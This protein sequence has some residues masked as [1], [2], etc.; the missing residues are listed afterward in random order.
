MN[1][2][3]DLADLVQSIAADLPVVLSGNLVGIY[4]YGSLT[5]DA[6][7]ETCSDADIAVLIRRDLD[8]LEFAEIDAWLRNKAEINSWVGRL[9]MRFIIDHEFLDK[10]SRC[11]GFYHYTGKLVRHGSDGNPIIWMNIAQSGITLWGEDG[12]SVAPYVSDSCLNKALL[13]E[14]DYLREGLI[15]NAGDRSGQAFVYSAYAVLTACRILYTASH[16]TLTSKDRAWCW[17][18]DVITPEWRAVIHAAEQNRLKGNG[19]TTP[20]MEQSAMR[21]VEFVDDEV[22]LIS[23]VAVSLEDPPC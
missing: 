11:C 16:G 14:L 17:A 12:K 9:D 20:E 23:K 4:V 5:Y 10:T 7:N 1:I 15:A 19:S 18:V 13:L 22:N 21:F 8:E 2:P 3:K 6:F